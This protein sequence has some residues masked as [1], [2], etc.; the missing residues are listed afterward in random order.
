MNY[1]IYFLLICSTTTAVWVTDFEEAK[2]I[3]TSSD[4][5]ILIYFSGSDWCRPCIQLKS[6]ILE[7]DVFNDF[8]NENLVMVLADFPKRKKN[9]LSED[10]QAHNDSLAEKYNLQGYFPLIVVTDHNGNVKGKTGYQK[11]S[12]DEYIDHLKEMMAN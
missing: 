10:Q 5:D 7:T 1:V 8:A 4:K 2:K 3:A 6:E 11:M 12:P 9:R